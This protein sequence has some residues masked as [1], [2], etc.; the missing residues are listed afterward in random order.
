MSAV[1]SRAEPEQMIVALKRRRQ[2][3]LL[4]ALAGIVLGLA[5]LFAATGAMYAKNPVRQLQIERAAL[6]PSGAR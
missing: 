2:L 5:T 1:D 3:G 4:F 6:Q